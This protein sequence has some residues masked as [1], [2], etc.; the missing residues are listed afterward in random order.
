[1]N[2][3]DIESWVGYTKVVNSKHLNFFT[4]SEQKIIAEI[5]LSHEGSVGLAIAMSESAIKAGADIIK[6]QA[7]FPSQ[8]S[9]EA[10]KFRVAFS[11]QDNSRWDY[12]ERTSFSL[13]QWEIIKASVEE[14][15][16]D[17][18][19]SVFSA[20]AVESFINQST[21]YIKLGSGDLTNP[22]LM[23]ALVDYEG[24][25]ILSSGLATW[26]EIV[27]ASKWIKESN[28]DPASALLQCTSLYPTPLNLVGLNVMSRIS[29]ELDLPSG[30][31]DH[32]IGI[33][34]ALT[35]LVH[36]A[37]YIEK[38][39]ILH[40]SFFGPDAKSSIIPDEL[41]TLCRFRDD[42]VELRSVVDKDE[43][44]LTL[45][46]TKALFGRSLGLR[47]S[48]FKG[49]TPQLNDFCLRKPSGGLDWQLRQR[50]QGLPL[51]KDY[52]ER[53]LLTLDH[54]GIKN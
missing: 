26:N 15:G 3:T 13:S 36:G 4:S 54:F 12:W 9:S 37:S 8:E 47:K 6:F 38:H 45:A 34:S 21:K 17:F 1:M 40:K 43:L 27:H 20:Y 14:L 46:P 52:S 22:E 10:E 23:E 29:S 44:A 24:T 28:F 5:G 33:S 35:A 31:S 2:H 18:A 30:L 11:K 19:V 41:E 53:E 39:F 51:V 49:E 16:A 48:F 42:L 50:I 7:H 32:S 25:V